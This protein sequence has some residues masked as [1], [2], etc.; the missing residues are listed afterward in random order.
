M[1]ILENEQTTTLKGFPIVLRTKDLNRGIIASREF[2]HPR[3]VL[4]IYDNQDGEVFAERL[5]VYK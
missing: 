3:T 4:G 5:L 1:N 2:Y